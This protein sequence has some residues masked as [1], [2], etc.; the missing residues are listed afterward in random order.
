MGTQ[1]L[2]S[3]PGRTAVR[4]LARPATAW[5]LTVVTLAMFLAFAALYYSPV[6]PAEVYRVA[7][8]A[9]VGIFVF[10]FLPLAVVGGF[11]AIRRPSNPIGW[12]LLGSFTL[13][14]TGVL[15]TLIGSVLG[16]DHVAAAPWVALGAA[17]WN[18]PV[19]PAW[20]G[21]VLVA[22]L[23]PDGHLPSPRWRWL[24]V[25][26]IV[27]T[28]IGL[29]LSVVDPTPNALSIATSGK[30]IPFH[31]VSPLG[32]PGSASVVH[33]LENVWGPIGDA[34]VVV[35]LV[36]VFL[37]GRGADADQ[38]HQVRWFLLGALVEAV[39]VV[40]GTSITAI[41][42]SNPPAAAVAIVGIMM[43]VGGGAVP[44]AIAVAIF[45]YRLYDIDLVISRALVYG[46][47]AVLITGV[48]VG[49][50]V[51]IGELVG[52]GGKPNL[53][54]SIL[55]T[56][57]V[58]VGFQPVRERLQKVA[59]RLVYGQRATPY[60]VLSEFSSRVAESYPGEEVLARMAR[61]LQ[62]GTG[63][64]A[65]TVWLRSGG[66]LRPA[67]THPESADGHA[68]VAIAAGT[69]PELPNATRTVAVRHQDEILGAL[70]VIKRRGEPLTPLEDKLLDDLAHQA[71]LVLKNVGLTTDLQ[72]RLEELRQSRQ[73]LVSAQDQE[74]RRL[75]RNLHDGA[76]QH[77]VALK[78]KLGLVEMLLTR[79]A[80]K[81]TATL[82]QLKADADEALTTLRDLARGIYPPLLADKGL[83]AALESQARKATIPVSVDADGVG[84]H[85]QDV[86]AT[87]YFC[88]LEALQNVQKYA[89]ASQVTVRL[90]EADG[91]LHFE[92]DDDGR[93]FD[94][95]TVIR[96]M[97]LTNMGDRLDS[98]GG[99][100]QI[101]SQP[102]RGSRLGGVIPV[103][104]VAVP[105]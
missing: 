46:S 27:A 90:R 76:Q 5:A 105:V 25:T 29:S 1:T 37:R 36:S 59:N 45:K 85:P 2:P 4:R 57:I 40:T 79:D 68:P 13:Y 38:R 24:A 81:A 74:R 55:A 95:A 18:S 65:A 30:G 7:G 12:L 86:E 96:G 3:T 19:D 70:S 11:L 80:D 35:A 88:V 104:A 69:I 78:V 102:G 31:I 83:A 103:R 51:G 66:E 26:A 23:F 42:V 21:L 60:E 89:G 6:T 72:A 14:M 50:A 58:A 77:L 67:A 47:L 64:E 9:P 53:G 91:A 28:C 48:Y 75:E 10:P 73:R 71:G 99:S 62:E 33:M 32:I 54:L 52:S 100:L 92:V 84:R 34:V 49:I 82:T 97:G 101:S 20:T 43:I 8:G 94:P 61:V 87:V 56:A 15:C 98:L 16:Y 22:L 17:I 39:L 44:V 41:W 93:G 63:A